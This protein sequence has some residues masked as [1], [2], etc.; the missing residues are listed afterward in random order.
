MA[1]ER[2]ETGG[3]RKFVGEGACGGTEMLRGNLGVLV[4]LLVS[5][6]FNLLLGAGRNLRFGSFLNPFQLTLNQELML[7]R[8]IR[9][10]N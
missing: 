5:D 1:L 4:L 6:L 7:T 9:L 2:G 8:R 3:K 10:F